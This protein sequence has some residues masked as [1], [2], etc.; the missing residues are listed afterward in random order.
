[1]AFKLIRR[2]SDLYITA[3]ERLILGILLE[4]Q[5]LFV[6]LNDIS[7]ELD[8]S[9]RTV[10]REIKFLEDTLA[11]SGLTLEKRINEGIRIDGSEENMEILKEELMSYSDFELQ[12]N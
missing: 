12:R 10:Q 1:M 9:L 11:E 6:S 3:R 4:S 7:T 2:C 5:H 8:V